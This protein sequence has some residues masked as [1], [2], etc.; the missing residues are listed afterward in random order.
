M[1]K[2]L[3]YTILFLIG[4][5]FTVITVKYI[6]NYVNR[7]QI[8][9]KICRITEFDS[10]GLMAED[11]NEKKSFYSIGKLNEVDI[12]DEENKQLILSESD[13]GQLIEVHYYGIYETYPGMFASIKKIVLLDSKH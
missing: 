11:V 3:V 8:S 10:S 5:C 7:P 2:S 1:K 12:R 13:V 9:I 6:I 4:L